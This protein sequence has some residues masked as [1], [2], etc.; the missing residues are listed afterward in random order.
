MRWLTVHMCLSSLCH[1]LPLSPLLS[2]LSLLF[3]RVLYVFLSCPF[4]FL[5]VHG[6]LY[7][8][9]HRCWDLEGGQ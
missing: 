3:W 5:C 1:A 9:E 6:V 7:E 4:V 2:S 8:K